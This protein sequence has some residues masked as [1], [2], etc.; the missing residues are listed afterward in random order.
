VSIRC[1]HGDCEFSNF[2]PNP[3]EPRLCL[4]ML[5]KCETCFTSVTVYMQ[6]VYHC[7]STTNAIFVSW[8]TTFLGEIRPFSFKVFQYGLI[9][10]TEWKDRVY[11]L[12]DQLRYIWESE[13]LRRAMEPVDLI[14]RVSQCTF[15]SFNFFLLMGR[16]K[17][18]SFHRQTNTIGSS[19][20]NARCQTN[21]N[22]CW[23]LHR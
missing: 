7:S 21:K 6:L 10:S 20:G 4:Y 23:L 3:R 13:V 12:A 2:I 17:V 5:Y 14:K 22:S 1:K 11:C 16:R 9:N 18:Y 15:Y 8:D 19:L